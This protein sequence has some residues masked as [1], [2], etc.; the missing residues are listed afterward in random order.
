MF[1]AAGVTSLQIFCKSHLFIFRSNKTCTSPKI[2]IL[3]LQAR[4][5]EVLYNGLIQI[6]TSDPSIAENVLDFL[7]PHF[8]N[9]YT[10]H[11][12]CPLKI[13]SCFKIENAK[14]S[15]VEPIDCLLSCISCILQVQQNSKCEQPRDAY[16]KC[17]GFA[18]SQDNEVCSFITF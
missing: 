16:W 18:P 6:V 12:E 11:A 3:L 9:Y 5:K 10:E 13:D 4:V 2:V 1:H 15:I 14:V 17:F 8:L 7:W